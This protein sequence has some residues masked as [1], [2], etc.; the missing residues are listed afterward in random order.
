MVAVKP[1]FEAL[2]RGTRKR[3]MCGRAKMEGDF[4]ELRVP[5]RLAP[6]HPLPNFQSTW[7]LAPT[8]P[9]PIVRRDRDDG[10]R[11]LDVVRWG[12][13]PYWAK[14]AKLSYST[15]NA[16]G[17]EVAIK[18]IFRDA[19]KRRRCLVPLDAFYEWAPSD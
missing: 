4:S 7:N 2:S 15:F 10:L 19:F 9:I 11:R 3:S 6:N 13:L 1:Q 14:D 5:F 18:P 16:R 12:L 8:D 17:E